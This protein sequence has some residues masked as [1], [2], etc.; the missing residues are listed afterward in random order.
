MQRGLD[1]RDMAITLQEQVRAKHDFLAPGGAI[2]FIQNGRPILG[3]DDIGSFDLTPTAT[4]QLREHTK[5]PKPYWDRCADEAPGLLTQNV[6]HWLQANPQDRMVRTLGEKARAVLSPG[7]RTL[8]NIDLAGVILPIIGE[9][10]L[11]IHSSN[12]SDDYF[13]L[14]AFSPRLRGEVE[15]GDEVELG[16]TVRNSE[17]GKGRLT[18]TRW[19]H[20]LVCKNGMKREEVVGKTHLGSKNHELDE[21]HRILRDHTK[22]LNDEAFFETVRDVVR[23][24]VTE[25]MLQHELNQLREAAGEIIDI[26]ANRAVAAI[27]HHVSLTEEQ[28][29]RVL[30][31]LIASG[32]TS[33]WSYA[34]AVTKLANDESY[35]YDR[36]IELQEAGAK[37]MELPQTQWR[38]IAEKV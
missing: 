26:P 24:N 30:D 34:N 16:I 1:E 19:L 12:V 37:V 8:D 6:N 31:N 11:T 25:T 35:G 20:R 29:M 28:G 36:G 32:S 10:E 38:R 17:V 2:K 3:M 21:H 5:I 15:V 13:Y 22:R 27:S 23:H 7:Y 18:V 14:Q 33:R 4:G 9:E